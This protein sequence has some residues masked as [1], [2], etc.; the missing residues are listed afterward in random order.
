MLKATPLTVSSKLFPSPLFAHDPT[1]GLIVA[2]V[3]LLG[4]VLIS[5]FVWLG[6]T[7]LLQSLAAALLPTRHVGLEPPCWHFARSSLSVSQRPRFFRYFRHL[8]PP[9]MSGRNDKVGIAG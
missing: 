3:A 9:S 5:A 1:W 8:F 7:A 4:T 2:F 6:L